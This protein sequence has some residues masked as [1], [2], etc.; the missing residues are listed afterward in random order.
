[1]KRT[2]LKRRT[3]LTSAGKLARKAPMKRSKRLRAVNRA[4]AAKRRAEDFGP[5]SELCHQIPCAVCSPYALRAVLL[6]GQLA[7][8]FEQRGVTVP[9]HE[10]PR[11]RDRR[12]KDEDCVPLCASNPLVGWEGHHE[13]RHRIG[14]KAFEAKHGINLDVVKAEV[15]G[16]VA[17]RGGER[18]A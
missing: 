2:T 12:G 5:Q 10:P 9:H 4:R 15:R 3:P 7:N 11:G 6:T 14:R 18:A 8:T 17:R 1:M 13:Q 16:A